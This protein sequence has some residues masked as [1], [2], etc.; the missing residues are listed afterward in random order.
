MYSLG[1]YAEGGSQGEP[2]RSKRLDILLDPEATKMAL[3]MDEGR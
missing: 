3:Y 2:G 1:S